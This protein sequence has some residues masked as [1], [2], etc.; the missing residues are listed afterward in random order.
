MII[1]TNYQGGKMAGLGLKKTGG[2]PKAAARKK[3]V[4]AA[5]TTLREAILESFDRVGGVEYLAIQAYVNPVAY[6]GLL[7]SVIPKEV[8]LKAE[9]VNVVDVLADL[10]ERLPV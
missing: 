8:E 3:N 1:L 10:A 9:N 4:R 5:Q 7:K 2:A 6:L